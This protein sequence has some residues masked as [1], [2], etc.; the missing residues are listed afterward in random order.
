MKILK[1]LTIII[2][3]KTIK[4]NKFR[5]IF[6]KDKKTFKKLQKKEYN[7]LNFYLVLESQLMLWIFFKQLIV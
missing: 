5:S 1:S 6:A 2:K 4:T 7:L 3:I